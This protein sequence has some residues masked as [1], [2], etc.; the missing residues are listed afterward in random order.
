MDFRDTPEEASFRKEV[1]AWFQAN[2]PEGWG[3][4]SLYMESP[5]KRIEFLR[6]FQR[7]LYEGG[8]AGL[9][10]PKEYG[11]RGATL[12]EQVIFSQEAAR[13]KAP[14]PLGVIG[15]GMAGPTIIAHG[16]DEQKRRYL[17]KIL[18]GEEIWCQGFSE[19]GSGSDLAS[20]KATA[21]LDG[22]AYVVNGQKVWTSY[23]HI[24]D[25]CILLARTDNTGPKHS[26]ITYFL[27][28]M[29]A[30]GVEV[31]PLRQITGDA[32]FNELFL[33]DVRIPK[34][35]ILGEI[36]D[37]WR[38]AM[39]TLLHERGTLGF[40]LAVAGGV[41]LDE[42]VAFA[43]TAPRAGGGVAYDDPVVRQRIAKLHEE[44]QANLLN[45][46][47]ALATMMKTGIPGP[48]GSLSKLM[49]SETNQELGKLAVEI[50]GGYGLLEAGERPDV[51]RWQYAH[52]RA[53]GNSIEA[54]TS[55][56][57]R[58]IIAERV[59]GLPKHK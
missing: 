55:E 14:Q 49:F 53:R 58:N 35:N 19:P 34:E 47:R 13:A 6:D 20:L 38:I 25:W 23:A 26:G 27:M 29:H 50:A 21:V 12:I 8:W 54:G 32:Q 3:S 7:K 30:P 31:R 36:N 9:S 1:R 2:L 22:D 15:L 45:N 41:A 24:A 18:S 48:E 57:L 56:I 16:T 28:D 40:A 11:G 17:A 46:Y 5:D 52:L 37:G 44:V 10:W 39:T 4:T 59:L 42:L 43:K 51:A 33:T